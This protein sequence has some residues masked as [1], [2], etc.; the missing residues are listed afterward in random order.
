MMPGMPPPQPAVKRQRLGANTKTFEHPDDLLTAHS[1]YEAWRKHPDQL[2]PIGSRKRPRMVSPAPSLAAF[3]AFVGVSRMTIHKQ[4]AR[5]DEFAEAL[6]LIKDRIAGELI[7][8][9]VVRNGQFTGDALKVAGVGERIEIVTEPKP[10]ET[11]SQ[12]AINDQSAQY[13]PDDKLCA[14][15]LYTRAQIEAGVPYTPHGQ[16]IEGTTA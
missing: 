10:T 4:A 8:H 2:I 9:G 12:R 14:G 1:R 11:A 5:S 6:N 16:I 3:A 7:S 15:P 13:H